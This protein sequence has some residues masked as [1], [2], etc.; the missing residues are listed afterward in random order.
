MKNRTPLLLALIFVITGAGLFFF[1]K[2]SGTETYVES[3]EQEERKQM[4]VLCSYETKLHQQILKEIAND[5]SNQP[6]H[7]RVNV[8]FIPKENFKKE[9]CMRLDSGS[10][11]DLIICDNSMMPALIDM[12]VFVDVTDYVD[13][14]L[15]KSI[16]FPKLWSTTMD[17]GKYYGVP[18]T[19]DPYV[20]FYN[21]NILEEKGEAVPKSWDDLLEVCG[22]LQQ[23]GKEEFG[24]AAKRPE[25]IYSFYINILNAFGGNLSTVDQEGGLKAVHVIEELKRQR[26]ISSQTINLTEADVARSFANGDIM[27]MANR[28]SASTILRSSRM[29]FAAGIEEMPYGIKESLILTG[30]NIGI[31]LHADEEAYDFLAY[32]YEDIVQERICYALDTLPVKSSVPYRMKRISPD[33]GEEFLRRYMNEGWCAESTNSWFE[34]ADEVSG[35]LYSIMETRGVSTE[36]TL[37][38]MQNNIK[39]FIMKKR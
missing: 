31:T 35:S 4:Y 11:A 3:G 5:Y 8:E 38:R 12:G 25:E 2:M 1:G 39:L 13:G 14:K 32:L 30:E 36:D 21:R 26:Y 10:T 15:K 7:A 34:I 37:S 23:L 28:L 18:F 24:F 29:E 19:C 33:D 16:N 17:D 20:L 9:I 6:A 27:L 22:R